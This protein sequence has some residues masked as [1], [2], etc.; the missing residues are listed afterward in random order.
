MLPFFPNIK[1]NAIKKLDT[2]HQESS[3]KYI[4]LFSLISIQILF[5]IIRSNRKPPKDL[6]AEL[7]CLSVFINNLKRIPAVIAITKNTSRYV[8]CSYPNTLGRFY[9]LYFA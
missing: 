3:K 7:I 8:R 9:F 4:L 5:H 6:I 2:Q 1:A